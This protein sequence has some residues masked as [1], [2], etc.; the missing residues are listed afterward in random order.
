MIIERKTTQ[1]TLEEMKEM[2]R[3]MELNGA[4]RCYLDI[5]INYNYDYTS[6]YIQDTN[7]QEGAAAAITF[8]HGTRINFV[9]D[10][11]T[12][13]FYFLDGLFDAKR[14]SSIPTYEDCPYNSDILTL[15]CIYNNAITKI[16]FD[17]QVTTPSFI[18]ITVG[19]DAYKKF[20]IEEA[21]KSTSIYLNNATSSNSQITI[22]GSSLISEINGLQGGFQNIS[23]TNEPGVAKSL[24]SFNASNSENISSELPFNEMVFLSNGR[25]SLESINLSNTH[26]ASLSSY[27][28]NLEDFNKLLNVDINTSDVTALILPKT[29][30][31]NLNIAKSKIINFSLLDQNIIDN[32]NFEGCD[33]LNTVSIENCNAIT[34]L[35]ISKKPNLNTVAIINND[36]LKILNLSNDS[37][38]SELTISNNK[39]LETIS[40]NNVGDNF[41]IEILSCPAL[42]SFTINNCKS[43]KPIKIDSISAKNII[44]ANFNDCYNLPGISYDEQEIE[45]YEGTN[46]FDVS[47]MEYIE[48]ASFNNIFNLTYLRVP[49]YNDEEHHPFKVSNGM[50]GTSSIKRIFGYID[51]CGPYTFERLGDFEINDLNSTYSDGSPYS[52]WGDEEPSF[53]EDEY[54]TNIVITTKTLEG[55]FANTNVNLG[56]LHYVFRKCNNGIESVNSAF[57]NCRNI[58]AI[59]GESDLNGNLFKNC[60]NI[61]NADYLFDGCVNISGK[62]SDQMID[63]ITANL[64]SFINVFP[65]GLFFNIPEEGDPIFNPLNKIKIIEGFEPKFSSENEPYENWYADTRLLLQGLSYVETIK[66]SFN[67]T[68]VL[69]DVENGEPCELLKGLKNLQIVENSFNCMVV[70]GNSMDIY[71]LLCD[72]DKIDDYPK[73]LK[74]IKNSFN[75]LKNNFSSSLFI[76]N[77]FFAS[78]KNS[79]E[80]V[81]GSF[82]GELFKRIDYN[83]CNELKFPYEILKGCNKLKNAS[84]LFKN[85]I[86]SNITRFEEDEETGE[87]VIYFDDGYN[88]ITLPS[89]IDNERIDIFGDCT[90]L[91]NISSCFKGMNYGYYELVGNGF[92]NNSLVNEFLSYGGNIFYYS[93]NYQ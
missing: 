50:F 78:C 91:E 52:E 61:T 69:L 21:N 1:I 60:H 55:C 87:M 76:G 4:N 92:K 70:G 30:L 49:N 36:S 16:I 80:E 63:D 62:V 59:Q 53:V 18:G 3:R 29:Q 83:D 56:D 45:Q 5:D 67:I 85:L 25:S 72:K 71:K 39:S 14:L 20:Y 57:R 82:T 19:N 9:K 23:S 86:I 32:I 84:G 79:I 64:E 74:K 75:F 31:Q 93:K 6:K 8:L 65:S 35:D 89:Y 34:S 33:K 2:V 51:I 77:S 15:S 44:N 12:R 13:H 43:A 37:S 54:F 10:W 88:T 66:N 17:I 48:N 26:G 46:V 73:K 28:I 81:S 38:L 41:Q 24:N 90:L 47:P 58:Y 7:E 40:I 22:K 27:K 68:Q 11:L 42:K